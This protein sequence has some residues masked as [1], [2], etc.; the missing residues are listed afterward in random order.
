MSATIID[1]TAFAH[2]ILA[3]TASRAAQFAHVRGRK[4]CL[5]T[6]LVGADPA[7]HPYVRMKT[8]RCR[9]T[10]ST[11]NNIC[12]LSI[13]STQDA[14]GLVATLAADAHVDG[15]LVRHPMP[16]QIDERAVFEAITP[17][18]DVDGVTLTSFAAMSLGTRG[19]QSCT[20][21][22]IMRLLDAY[23]VDP[24]G[25]RAVVVGRSPILGRP[26]G[27]LLARAPDRIGDDPPTR[28]SASATRR[29]VIWP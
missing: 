17:T 6:V 21:G 5:A 24:A 2:R 10:V 9:S 7:S 4:P 22:G 19:F 1:G 12:S 28:R 3:E 15:I 14:V 18:I 26:V 29:P 20:P 11:P 23:G 25:H 13:S 8:N 16:A 27:M